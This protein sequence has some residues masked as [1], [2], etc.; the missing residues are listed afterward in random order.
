VVIIG[1]AGNVVERLRGNSWIYAKP[2]PVGRPPESPYGTRFALGG[3]LNAQSLTPGPMK[4]KTMATE[5][6]THPIYEAFED[7][8]CEGD[9]RVEAVDTESEGECYVAIFT[10]P[11]AEER[12]RE[13]A[14]WKNAHS[15]QSSSA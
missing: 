14:A 3:I 5:T 12:A 10:G 7:R 8:R 1:H 6:S 13:Y 15:S 4:G 2:W 11:R 9:W